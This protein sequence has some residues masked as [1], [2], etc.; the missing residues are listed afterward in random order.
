MSTSEG[1]HRWESLERKLERQDR[2]Y[3]HLR[4]KDDGYIGRRMLRMEL[5]GKRKR[6]RP[7]RRFMDVVKEDMA[8]VE[9]TEEDTVDRNNWRRKIR[10]GDPWWE[11]AER[12]RRRRIV[13][14]P[15]NSQSALGKL[16]VTPA[17]QNGKKYAQHQQGQIYGP[18]SGS[19]RERTKISRHN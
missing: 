7:K 4:R 10:C 13:Q 19:K 3:G 14:R 17:G 12:R 5:P 6:G 2:W 11:K 8:E 15:G 16:A 1:Q 18:T 9:V